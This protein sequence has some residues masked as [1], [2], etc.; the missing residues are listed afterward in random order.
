MADNFARIFREYTEMSVRY[1]SEQEAVWYYLNPRKRPCF[2]I[3][4]LKEIK[5][6][7]ESII[8][9]FQADPKRKKNPVRYL[10]L[11]SQ[12]PGIFNFG[13][14]LDLFVQLIIEQNRDRLLEY[15]TS[16]ID[17]LYMNAVSLHLPLTLISC[18]E[19]T[20]LGGGFEAAL[21]TNVLIAEKH[22]QMGVPEIRF[23]LFPGMGAYSFLARKVGVNIAERLVSN[24]KIYNASELHG[25]GIVDV[26]AEPGKGREA[27]NN[28]INNHKQAS[29]GMQ[30]IQAVKRFYNPVT[31]EELIGITK[32]WVDAALQLNKKN[33]LLMERLVASQNRVT[34]NLK[35]A[36]SKMHI[37]RTMQDRRLDP[38]KATFPLLDS[39]GKQI[40]VDRRRLER[41]RSINPKAYN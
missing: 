15:A 16:C 41:R 23:N 12:T 32:I 19:G 39:S 11:A 27:L 4:L 38:R 21:S 3:V 6:L 30:A 36:S 14:D 9:Y 17:V 25:M 40:Q 20:A 7:Q 33:L 24:G 34:F 5:Q 1:D 31:Y 28:F 2:S 26:L 22:A 8:R 13:G 37:V 10:I 35:L 18:V 29:N